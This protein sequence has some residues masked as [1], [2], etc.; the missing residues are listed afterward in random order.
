MSIPED[1]M[2]RVAGA[3][4]TIRRACA[5]A[6]LSFVA[7][8]EPRDVRTG[9]MIATDE[10]DQTERTVRLARDLLERGAERLRHAHYAVVTTDAPE[11]KREG[12]SQSAALTRLASQVREG[13]S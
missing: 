10:D 8:V 12:Q 7:V 11:D 2:A 9:V 13:D 4:A 5:D 1:V 6:N 3:I